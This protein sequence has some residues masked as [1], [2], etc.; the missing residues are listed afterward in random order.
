VN[1]RLS[2]APARIRAAPP[3]AVDLGL[4]GLVLAEGVVELLAWDGLR[5]LEA[6]PVIALV[7][8]GV[9]L[10]RRFPIG[11]VALAFAGIILTGFLPDDAVDGL[12]GPFLAV[13]FVVFSMALRVDGRRLWAGAAMAYGGGLVNALTDQ[14]EDSALDLFFVGALLVAA[15]VAAGRLVRSRTQLAAALAEKAARGDRD[16]DRRAE[17]AVTAERTRIAGELHDVVAHAL[18]AMT[19]QAA[20]ARRLAEKDPGRASGAFLAI[21]QTGREALSELRRLLG[22]MRREDEELALAP[23]PRLAHLGDLVRRI[24]A[25]GLP[26]VFDVEGELDGP[27][28]PGIDLVAYRVVQEALGEALRL[29]GA[30]AAEVHVRLRGDHILLE[31]T[32]DGRLTDRRLLGM[33][34]RVRVYGG[35]FE[36]LPRRGGGH[37]VRARLP[38][39]APA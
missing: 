21:E 24:E 4:A 12:G 10:R 8:A 37:R 7:A 36:A 17:E 6:V 3:H 28:P 18:G 35:E 25:A 5:G 11:A 30:G 29:G 13:I 2:T 9:Y 22:V 23:Q 20:A 26:V 27:L 19:V 16:R 14:F 38:L 32:D 15:P 34:E 31:V 39:E 33:R 1:R